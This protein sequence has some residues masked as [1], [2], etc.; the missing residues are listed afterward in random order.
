MREIW[1][2]RN[3]AVAAGVERGQKFARKLRL[4][5]RAYR[6]KKESVSLDGLLEPEKGEE[7]ASLG[8]LRE[9][10]K[11]DEPG[12]LDELREPGKGDESV[13]SDGS[14]GLGEPGKG[15]ESRGG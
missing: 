12:S 5:G 3:P 7:S 13:S 4:G 2:T 15:D 1:A 9:P 10:E 14:D 8:G 6:R 11:G